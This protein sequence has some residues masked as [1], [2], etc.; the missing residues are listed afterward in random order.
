MVMVLCPARAQTNRDRQWAPARWYCSPERGH[1]DGIFCKTA[2]LKEAIAMA[3]EDEKAAKV[4]ALRAAILAGTAE[5]DGLDQ[6]NPE[7]H[8]MMEAWCSSDDPARLADKKTTFMCAK[9]RAKTDFFK[10]REELLTYWCQEQG[11]AGSPKCKQMEFGKRMQEVSLV[12]S[13]TQRVLWLASAPVSSCAWH[14]P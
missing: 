5:S 9:A 12:G 4:D 8:R 13:L 3:A 11:K 14:R 7:R 6:T 10:R 1:G 2:V